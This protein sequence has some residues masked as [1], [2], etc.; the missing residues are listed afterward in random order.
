MS[1]ICPNRLAL[2]YPVPVLHTRAPVKPFQQWPWICLFPGGR[3]GPLLF[4]LANLNYW[5]QAERGKDDR[6]LGCSFGAVE[7]GRRM[8]RWGRTSPCYQ[9]QRGPRT[10][11]LW[12][13]TQLAFSNG[14]PLPLNSQPSPAI[15]QYTALDFCW[16]EGQACG[17][18]HIY[19]DQSNQ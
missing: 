13:R 8:E 9:I 12:N 19:P 17:L 16:E 18:E 4:P 5:S 6:L 10:L 7:A 14:L 3:S 15:P 2:M 1:L 11:W